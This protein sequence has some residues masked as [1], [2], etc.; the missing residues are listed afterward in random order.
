MSK[1]LFILCVLSTIG[2]KVTSQTQVSIENLKESYLTKDESEYM[3]QFPKSMVSFKSYFGWDEELDKPQELYEESY[4]YIDY[5]FEL[6]D[7]KRFADQELYI[8]DI[9]ENGKWQADG[10]NYFQDK[11]LSYI[12]EKNKY[13]LINDLDDSRAKSVLF[14]LF[15]SPHP[16]MDMTFKMHLDSRK[17]EILETLFLEELGDHDRELVEVALADYEGN[18][19]YFIKEID[20]NNDNLLDKVVSSAAYQGDE[21]LVFLNTNRSFKLELVSTNFSEDGGCQIVDIRQST[22]GNGMVLI[23][24][25]MDRGLLEEYYH[26]TFDGKKWELTNTIFRTQ[27]S[28]QV[29]AVIYVC[30]V[31][32]EL[33]MKDPDLLDKLRY[34]PDEGQREKVCSTEKTND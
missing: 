12:K 2:C 21:L 30:D 29:D 6:I 19:S 34:I 33:N 11:A 27:S 22:T 3:R 32:Q 5:W 31:K 18:S 17:Q 23:L 26:I 15:D 25:F 28:N 20:V 14:F 10:V 4:Q 9:C 1:L 8:T 7:D 24:S 16:S 13:Y